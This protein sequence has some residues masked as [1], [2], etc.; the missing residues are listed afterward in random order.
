M[1]AFLHYL[2]KVVAHQ[3]CNMCICSLS[4]AAD[5]VS[6]SLCIAWLMGLITLVSLS[7]RVIWAEL[8]RGKLSYFSCITA[9]CLK[10]PSHSDYADCPTVFDWCLCLI[11]VVRRQMALWTVSAWPSHA[12][13]TAGGPCWRWAAT[14]AASSSGTSSR[15]ALQKLSAHTSIQC[16]LCGEMHCTV[17][18][19]W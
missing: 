4:L 18:I 16:A 15:G 10:Y 14:M 3:I 6:V 12:H 2:Q 13:S 5:C 8:S 17:S 7:S 9:L 19:N 11:C 1:K